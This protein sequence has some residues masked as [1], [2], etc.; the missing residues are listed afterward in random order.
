[1]SYVWIIFVLFSCVYMNKL[2]ILNIYL[3]IKLEIKDKKAHSVL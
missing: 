3:Y 1:M 2:F